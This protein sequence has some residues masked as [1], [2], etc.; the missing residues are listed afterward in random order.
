MKPEMDRRYPLFKKS[1]VFDPRSSI[2]NLSEIISFTTLWSI[3]VVS[4]FILTAVHLT[5]QLWSR[6]AEHLPAQK[7]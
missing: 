2:I 7:C 6:V 3:A 4:W 5:L 1:K